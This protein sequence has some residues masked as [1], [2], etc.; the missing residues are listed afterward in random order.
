MPRLDGFGLL[1]RLREQEETAA[2]P[3]IVVTGKT[4]S[5]DEMSLLNR[6]TQQV[7]Q[8]RGLTGGDLVAELQHLLQ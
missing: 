7:L 6:G 5:A 4:L 3:V 8:K 2:I 1:A